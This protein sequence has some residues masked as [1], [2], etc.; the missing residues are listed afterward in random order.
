MDNKVLVVKEF[1]KDCLAED[2]FF[3][4][5]QK[6]HF[7]LYS[8]CDNNDQINLAKI[9]GVSPILDTIKNIDIVLCHEEK[10]K[11]FIAAVMKNA[12]IY[13]NQYDV[14]WRWGGFNAECISDNAFLIPAEQR[15]E[16]ILKDKY[17][18]GTS[19]KI[20]KYAKDICIPQNCIKKDTTD[21]DNRLL[22]AKTYDELLNI[23][24]DYDDIF[25]WY[26]KSFEIWNNEFENN[27]HD[28]KIIYQYAL[29]NMDCCK[30]DKARILFEKIFNKEKD[31][32]FF[33]SRLAIL[34]YIKFNNSGAKNVADMIKDRSLL[35][36]WGYPYEDIAAKAPIHINVDTVLENSYI[37]HKINL[38]IM[39]MPLPDIISTKS[40]IKRYM[41][42]I[43]NKG[44][45]VTKEETVRQ[46]VL[47]YLLDEL[48]IPKELIVS[49]DH[50]AHYE[51][52][53]TIRADITVRENDKTLLIVECK[54][55][56]VSLDGEP[57]RQI[58]GYNDILK[59]K[60]LL[61]TNGA[62]SYIFQRND[63]GGYDSIMTL[64]DYNEIKSGVNIAPIFFKKSELKRPSVAEMRNHN[65]ITQ[66]KNDGMYV[67]V[68]TPDEKVPF[69]L[70]LLWAFLDTNN[71]AE[72]I[73][74]Y[75]ICIEKDYLTSDM[76]LTNVSGGRFPG[77][78]RQFLVRDRFGEQL[79][80]SFAVL[81]NFAESTT[82]G[83]YTSLVCGV[84]RTSHSIARLE[85]R[86]DAS[87]KEFMTKTVLFHSGI[88]SRKK[89]QTTIDYIYSI[90]PKLIKN[91]LVWLGEF[92]NYKLICMNDKNVQDFL[93]RLIAYV[94]LRDEMSQK[95]I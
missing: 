90:C 16:V 60:Y 77:R 72:N 53:A 82:K 49:E 15:K 66:Y 95:G 36:D 7:G 33:L 85:L 41:D 21:I 68:N 46:K 35:D 54:E 89:A 31:D 5:N 91:N 62:E 13:S 1:N 34:Y 74:G 4:I 73:S 45:P 48:K 50:L 93:L 8:M 30:Y 9:F 63:M 17:F 47:R 19:T 29:S 84:D 75:G 94:L 58:F 6:L 22:Q 18:W 76:E 20:S 40:G 44:I 59:S 12:T 56:N 67:G 71:T 81:G 2:W 69:I 43:R 26:D 25:H 32:D 24:I 92:S 83:G 27:K 28:E 37:K 88:R 42:P 14:N 64:P 80:I 87:I 70:N 61:L 79:I 57:V 55:P 52:D 11:C 23:S 38:G 3:E 65:I 86:L 51:K 10:E 39:D 78:Y